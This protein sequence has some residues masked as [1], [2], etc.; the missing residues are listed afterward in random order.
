METNLN[1]YKELIE[2][3]YLGTV[4]LTKCVLPHMI[5][6]KQGKIVTVN[7][8]LGIIAAPL[9]SGY[10]ASKHALRVRLLKLNFVRTDLNVYGGYGHITESSHWNWAVMWRDRKRDPR[11]P[12][13]EDTP[14]RY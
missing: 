13:A 7:S 3:N 1:V 14:R 11:R 9:S 12:V 8:L 5:E 2:L 6:R 4:S 10:C